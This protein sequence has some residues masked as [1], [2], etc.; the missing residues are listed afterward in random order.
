[1]PVPGSPEISRRELGARL[2]ALRLERGWTVEQVA[3]HL[4]FSTSKVSRLETGRRGASAH[5]I[6]QL[7]DLYVVGDQLR[8]DLAKLAAEGKHSAWYRNPDL[9]SDYAGLE[10]AAETISDFAL[11]V[12][13]GLLQTE[14]YARAVLLG[15]PP[16]LPPDVIEQRIAARIARQHLLTSDSR[17]RFAALV[18]EGVLHRLVGSRHVMRAQLERMLE[19]ASIPDVSVRVIPFDAGVLPTPNSKYIILTFAQPEIADTVFLEGLTGDN[20]VDRPEDIEVYKDAFAVMTGM[21]ADAER[22]RGIISSIAAQ[23]GS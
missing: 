15:H 5:D 20:Y 19:A 21:A 2:R 11:G 6:H 1:V 9:R 17:P 3:S 23:L 8:R 13:P 12:V 14:E 10:A 18:D 16:R 22:S 7:C 4:L